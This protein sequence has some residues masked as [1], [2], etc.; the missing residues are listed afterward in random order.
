[1]NFVQEKGAGTD[2]RTGSFHLSNF[3]SKF[4]E[5]ETKTGLPN[6]KR[7][8]VCLGPWTDCLHAW[9]GC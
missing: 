7:N 8:E 5:R 9:D 2:L 1:M 3:V 6:C 4:R